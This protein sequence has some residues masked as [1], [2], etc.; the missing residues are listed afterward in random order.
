M[1][2]F[3]H[4]EGYGDPVGED[5]RRLGAAHE[6]GY[7]LDGARVEIRAIVIPGGLAFGRGEGHIYVKVAKL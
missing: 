4:T 1:D 2:A 3:S 7:P 6:A 5:F